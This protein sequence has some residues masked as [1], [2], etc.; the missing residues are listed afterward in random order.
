M[1]ISRLLRTKKFETLESGERKVDLVSATYKFDETGTGYGNVFVSEFEIMRPD[2]MSMR[3][4]SDYELWD[5]I[6]KYNGVSNPFSLNVGEIILVPTLSKT[7]QMIV[8][9]KVVPEKGTEPQ[10]KNEERLMNPKSNKDKKRLES[11][12]TKVSEVVPPNVNL[13][14]AQNVRVVDGKT[15]FGPDMT[16]GA[17][18]TQSTTIT[19][20]RIQDQL[21]NNGNI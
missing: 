9:P 18:S 17:T 13:T 10:K 15:I 21:R 6:L 1:L 19:R 20:N 7:R 2:I 16:Q 5:V 12:R 14:G 3:V 11:I 4:Y 8:A